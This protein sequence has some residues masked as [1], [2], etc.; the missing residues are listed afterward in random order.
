MGLVIGVTLGWSMLVLL[1]F[2]V[3]M[4]Y[5]QRRIDRRAE[6]LAMAVTMA[7]ILALTEVGPIAYSVSPFATGTCTAASCEPLIQVIQAAWIAGWVA[8]GVGLLVFVWYVRRSGRGRLFVPAL[9]VLLSGLCVVG[10]IAGPAWGNGLVELAGVTATT[11]AIPYVLERTGLLR[12]ALMAQLADLATFGF[13]WQ[14]GYGERNPIGR[15]TVDGL[16]RLGSDGDIGSWQAAVAGGIVLILV[17]LAL[18]AFLIQ[19]TP[20]L[21]RYRRGVLVVA[22]VAGTV[23]AAVS[24]VTRIPSG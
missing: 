20:Y 6:V 16:I 4:A 12:A 3:V 1:L 2:L 21:G 17:K 18:I 15:W 5:L 23:G 8:A 7:G 22:M 19:V 24:V 13:V 14:L 11:V 9:G 10:V